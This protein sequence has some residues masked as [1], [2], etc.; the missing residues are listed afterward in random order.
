MELPPDSELHVCMVIGLALED[1]SGTVQCT[2]RAVDPHS[3]FTD[4]DPAVLLN[5]D[6][7]P[8]AFKMRIRIH[9]ASPNILIF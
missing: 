5:A 4:P 9:G 1:N 8:A 3:F 2:T 7:D 6:L